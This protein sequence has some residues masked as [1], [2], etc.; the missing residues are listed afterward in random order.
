MAEN[1][2]NKNKKEGFFKQVI[3]SVK[4]FDKYEEFGLEGIGKSCAYLLKMTAIIALVVSSVAIYQFSE[5]MTKTVVYF[6][7]NVQT[8]TYEDGK[9]SVNSDEKMEIDLLNNVTGKIT[10]DTSELTSEQIEEYKTNLSDRESGIVFLKDKLLIKNS[11]VSSIVETNY[12]DF[13]SKYN[14]E[15]LDKQ[16]VLNYVYENQSQI[17]ISVAVVVYI[18]MFAIYASNILVDSIGLAIL[19]FLVARIIGMKTRFGANFS[20]GIH[21]LTFPIILNILYIILN[22]F[23]GITIKY[24]QIMYTVISYIYVVASLLIIR[25]DYIKKEADLQKIQSEQEKVRA[26][27]EFKKQQEKDE[28]AKKKNEEE[29]QKQKEK[30]K[31]KNDKEPEEDGKPQGSNA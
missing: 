17:Y 31:E 10:I 15:S 3:K 21:A 26:E 7:D 2:Q 18:Y 23:T 19:G 30:E 13:L 29:K 14:I 11:T 22:A 8:L 25:T 16:Q 1:V 24:F 20:M 6:N 27:I 12:A 5:T 28:E 4:D 9:L